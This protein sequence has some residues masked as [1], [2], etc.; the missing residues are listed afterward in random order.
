ML[1]ELSVALCDSHN[2]F[3]RRLSFSNNIYLVEHALHSLPQDIYSC[4]HEPKRLAAIIYVYLFLRQIPHSAGIYQPLLGRL[5]AAVGQ[6][7]NK[8]SESFGNHPSNLFLLWICFIGAA[9]S[10][11]PNKIECLQEWWINL[12]RNICKGLN[13][14]SEV[15]FEIYLNRVVEMGSLCRELCHTVWREIDSSEPYNGENGSTQDR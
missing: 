2:S 8:N 15:S 6:S 14:V 9:S 5:H 3:S 4:Y 11:P 13:V 12:L 10:G 7:I 1:S